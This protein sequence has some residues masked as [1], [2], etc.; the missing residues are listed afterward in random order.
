ME[1]AEKIKAETGEMPKVFCF[2]F[3]SARHVCGMV[4]EAGM[5][6]MQAK[7]VNFGDGTWKGGN[8]DVNAHIDR[9]V[10]SGAKAD[11]LMIHG[12]GKE[13]GAHRPF[14]DVAHFERFLEE[15]GERE[16]KGDI[17]VVPYMEIAEEVAP[18]K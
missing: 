13:T 4:R 16:S 2:P 5:I 3:N 9:L 14:K 18:D 11:A 17:K 1:S 7:R 15:L 8:A 12:I 6:P 10:A